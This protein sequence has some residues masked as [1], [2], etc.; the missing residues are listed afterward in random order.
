MSLEDLMSLEG[1]DESLAKKLI[2]AGIPTVVVLATTPLTKLIHPDFGIELDLKTARQLLAAAQ[3]R[4]D[5]L[6]GFQTGDALIQQYQSRNYLTTGVKALDAIFPQ[7]T[8]LETQQVYE[9]YG[10]EGVGKAVLLH[11]LLCTAALPLNKGGL[12]SG[13]I[14]IDT[15]GSFSLPLLQQ[16]AERFAVPY[17]TLKRRILKVTPPASEQL[18]YFCEAQLE[19]TALQHGVRLFCLDSI[20]TP[21]QADYEGVGQPLPERQQKLGRL[22]QALKRAAQR[23]NGIALYTNQVKRGDT[24]ALGFLVGHGPQVRLRLDF[25]DRSKRGRVITIEKAVDS[26]LQTAVTQLTREGFVEPVTRKKRKNSK[27]QARNR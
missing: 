9:L 16:I 4:C 14:Y 22:I 21:F 2:A 10:P 5:T 1:I 27:K 3:T 24:H 20:A 12:A 8:G 18:L 23:T 7:G 25:H 19:P 26:P 6:F 15:E 13:A 17:D 11:Q